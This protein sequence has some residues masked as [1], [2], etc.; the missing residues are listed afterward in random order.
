MCGIICSSFRAQCAYFFSQ[1]NICGQSN[2]F[3]NIKACCWKG[4][5]SSLSIRKLFSSS[6]LH[7]TWRN[8]CNFWTIHTVKVNNIH[9][10]SV[11]EIFPP[12]TMYTRTRGRPFWGGYVCS[13]GCLSNLMLLIEDSIFNT[14]YHLQSRQDF[15]LKDLLS[16]TLFWDFIVITLE[17]NFFLTRWEDISKKNWVTWQVL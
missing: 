4:K 14:K 17:R 7:I 15:I 2:T 3:Q 5:N 10:C 1:K 9:S 8:S 13:R 11:G 16:A 6:K 12:Y